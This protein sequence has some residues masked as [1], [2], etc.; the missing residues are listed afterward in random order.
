MSKEWLN[1]LKIAIVGEDLKAISSLIDTPQ[2][3]KLD[4]LEAAS[5]IK[6][7][8]RLYE[9]KQNELNMEFEKL[10]AVRKYQL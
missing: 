2:I 1:A 3:D 4:V 8:I 10:K 9:S 7:A 5:L 6:E